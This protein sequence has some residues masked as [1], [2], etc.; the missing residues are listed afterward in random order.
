VAVAVAEG[1]DA[2]GG[3]SPRKEAAAETADAET[4]RF[5]GSEDD[6]FNAAA[7]F[8]TGL[9]ERA[10]GFEGAEDA[11]YTVIASSVWNGV[12]VGAGCNGRQVWIS[13]WPA[14]EDIADGVFA[15]GKVKL[16]AKV[17]D[18][19][20]GAEVGFG[21]KNP[22]DERWRSFGDRGE[23]VYLAPETRDIDGQGGHAR[24]FSQSGALRAGTARAPFIGLMLLV[25]EF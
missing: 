20:A 15:D 17:F 8:E 23:L 18:E 13:T 21:E 12:D 10:Y 25:L 2:L 14:S 7:R 3:Q 19:G 9:F 4:G 24:N 5:F 1:G 22:R 6:Q 11:H 16:G